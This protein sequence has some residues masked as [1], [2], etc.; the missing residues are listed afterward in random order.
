MKKIL[1]YITI[2][3]V[4]FSTM[5]V[6][7]KITAGDLD[8]LQITF[9]R[10]LIGGLFLLPFAFREMKQ[11]QTV[12]HKADYLQ[13]LFLGILCICIS[14]VFFQLGVEGSNAST[15]A[16][17]FS[18]NPLFT[19]VFAHLIT[20]E[21]LNVKKVV[22]LTFGLAGIVLMMRLWDIDPGNSGAG[23]AFSVI[24]AVIF[25]L[26]SAMSKS[27]IRK[28]GGLTQTSLSFLFGSL[29]MLPILWFAGKPVVSGINAGNILLVLYIGIMVSGLGYLFYFL[30]MERADAATASIVFFVKPALAP[31]IAVLV[32]EETMGIS[33]VFGIMLILIGSFINLK[34]PKRKGHL[35]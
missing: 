29:T 23:L 2:S 9:L 1:L 8:S 3:A 19:I 27:G 26:Y 16:V 11:K 10:F 25:G 30:I 12:L 33:E 20:E 6:A 4:L 7:L 28:R 31:V 22:A 5:E 14:M 17:I 15:A 24:S 32:L 13:L 21:K 18:I 34:K 35:E